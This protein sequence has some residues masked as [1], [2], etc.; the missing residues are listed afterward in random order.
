MN[1][2]TLRVFS[3]IGSIGWLL[4]A[5]AALADIV[6]SVITDSGSAMWGLMVLA[7][8]AINFN[9]SVLIGYKRREYENTTMILE[10]SE[11][12]LRKTSA[13]RANPYLN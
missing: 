7:L 5:I 2:N 3:A 10:K 12:M 6:R 8:I 4:M 11:Q 13:G 1:D 9:I